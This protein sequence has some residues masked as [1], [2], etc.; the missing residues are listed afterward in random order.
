VIHGC[1]TG[2]PATSFP[3]LSTYGLA[4]TVTLLRST[5]SCLLVKLLSSN[6]VFRNYTHYNSIESIPLLSSLTPGMCK[7]VFL[8]QKVH[9]VIRIQP[10]VLLIVN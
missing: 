10:G 1:E 5:V 3:E 9:G 4:T 8:N 6:Q 2:F 7:Y